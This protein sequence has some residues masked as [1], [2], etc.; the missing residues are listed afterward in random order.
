[1]LMIQCNKAV[2]AR[3]MIMIQCNIAVIGGTRIMVQCNNMYQ[4]GNGSCNDHAKM[5]QGC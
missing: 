2:I 5:P 3:V 1:M 4:S